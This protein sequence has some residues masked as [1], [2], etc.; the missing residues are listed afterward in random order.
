MSSTASEGRATITLEFFAG[1]DSEKALQDVRE[2]V[3]LAK[4]E[5]PESSEEP[6]IRGSR[7]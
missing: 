2:K 7:L 4:S 1:F 6:K 5:L 3:D